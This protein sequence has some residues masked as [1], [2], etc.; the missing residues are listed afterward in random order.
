MKFFQERAKEVKEGI[1]LC[2]GIKV[3][4]ISEED[5]DD[6][7]TE[8]FMVPPHMTSTDIFV[9]EKYVTDEDR[10]YHEIHNIM[11]NSVLALRLLKSGDVM[12]RSTFQILLA[13][14]RQLTGRTW[15]P[16]PN[17]EPLLRARY[18]LNYED[19]PALSKLL[20]KVLHIDFL[21]NRNLHLACKRFQRIYDEIE[22]EDKLIDLIIAFEALLL[23]GE[24][25]DETKGQKIANA[26][27]NLLGKNDE[28]REEI[29]FF[30]A[31][32]YSTRNLIVHGVKYPQPIVLKANQ[33]W[34]EEFVLKLEDYLREAIKKSFLDS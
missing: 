33:L 10:D 9:L 13:E 28:E 23:K 17:F 5:L 2:D 26:C 19:I 6:L 4:R 27:S 22:A 3:R 20:E 11:L 30:L 7:K 1:E 16:E 14:K 18:V 31:N 21:Q 12:G 15:E 34:I 8:P 24:R 29:R 25:G 32:A